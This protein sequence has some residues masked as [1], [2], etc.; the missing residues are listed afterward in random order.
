[1][2]SKPPIQNRRNSAQGEFAKKKEEHRNWLSQWKDRAVLML[3]TGAPADARARLRKAIEKELTPYGP[4]D[5]VGEITDIVTAIVE[6]EKTRLQEKKRGSVYRWVVPALG[7]AAVALKTSP[8][9]KL[10]KKGVAL[11]EDKLSNWI[12]KDANA[13]D[14]KDGSKGSSR[15]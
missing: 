7:I 6:K 5:P 12:Q 4:K 10:I 2:P 3:P 8:G 15:R 1:M 14:P 9:Q 13:K 11:I